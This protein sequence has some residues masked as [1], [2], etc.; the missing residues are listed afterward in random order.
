MGGGHSFGGGGFGGS[1]V[2]AY[3]GP[4][5]RFTSQARASVRSGGLGYYGRPGPGWG[6][7][8]QSRS[9]GTHW[10]F[11][12]APYGWGYGYPYYGYYYGYPWWG[13][14]S[15]YDEQ[16]GE[17]QIGN[18]V[19]E[20]PNGEQ[21]QDAYAQE[22]QDDPPGRPAAS[23]RAQ[24]ATVLVFRDGHEREIENYA[25]VA[26]TLWNFA[27]TRTEKIPL[28]SLDIPATIRTNDAR[29][30]DFQLPS[31]SEGQ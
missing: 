8:G 28:D 22:P 12:T 27:G 19:E 1:H 26:S 17:Q 20:Y 13:D 6:R 25:I 2:S 31:T 15:G 18:S 29:G 7:G 5:S 24:P 30:V 4:S 21:D 11:R 9:G 3:A 16:G 10:Y 14:D 23:Q